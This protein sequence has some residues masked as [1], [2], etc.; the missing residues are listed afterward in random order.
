MTSKKTPTNKRLASLSNSKIKRII[1]IQ[2]LQIK[3]LQREN[4]Q[5]RKKIEI[6]ESAYK[7]PYK[8]F[9]KLAY[10]CEVILRLVRKPFRRN[11]T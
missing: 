11:K 8:F 10:A 3:S 7:G 4:E 2:G 1:L 6:M 5:L 9:Y